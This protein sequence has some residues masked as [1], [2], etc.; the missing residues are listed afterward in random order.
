MDKQRQPNGNDKGKN[1]V[2]SN[3]SDKPKPNRPIESTLPP[4]GS[5]SKKK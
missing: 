2:K 1:S 4:P 3:S 5:G